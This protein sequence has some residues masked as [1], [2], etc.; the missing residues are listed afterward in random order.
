M[1]VTSWKLLRLG[2][3]NLQRL[4]QLFLVNV[5]IISAKGFE[6]AIQFLRLRSV[7]GVCF[8]KLHIFLNEISNLFLLQ[9]VNNRYN[10]S[11]CR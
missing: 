11:R 9:T 5:Y 4:F 7:I 1:I 10:N 3:G 2:L 8:T 6:M